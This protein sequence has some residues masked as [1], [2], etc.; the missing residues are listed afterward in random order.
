MASG[1]YQYG[2]SKVL[3]GTIDLD[4]ST[5]KVMLVTSSYTYDADHTAVDAGTGTDMESTELNVTGY[6]RAWGG[7]GRKTA[8]VTLQANNTNN[9]VDAA[10]ADLTWTAL[11]TGQTIGG[12]VLIKEGAANDT[13]SIP[14]AFFDLSD[15]AT[16]GGN[17]TLA[18]TALGSGGDL[19]VAV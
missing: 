12:A 9:R 16:T 5:L 7:A 15:M 19:R 13:Q 14:I 6:T 2:L 8:T 17:V 1:W 10:I 18:F 3:D 4:T 11:G